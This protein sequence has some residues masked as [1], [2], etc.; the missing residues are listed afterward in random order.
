[1]SL[2]PMGLKQRR[3]LDFTRMLTALVTTA[4]VLAG[5]SSAHGRRPAPGSLL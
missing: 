5:A 1:M 3:R 2:A 4:F